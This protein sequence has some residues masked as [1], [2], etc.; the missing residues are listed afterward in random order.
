MTGERLA[1]VA[2]VWGGGLGP[3]GVMRLIERFGTAAAVLGA[4]EDELLKARAR[5]SPQ[6]AQRVA[7]LADRLDAVE[8]E[9]IRLGD[10]E[11]EVVCA[12]EPEF[13]AVLKQVP[14]PP[15]ILSIRGALPRD[16]SNTVAIVGTRTP[17]AQGG[18]LARRLAADLV[19]RGYCIVSGLA[20]GTDAAGHEGALDA[21]GQTVAVLG[22]GIRVIHPRQNEGLAERIVGHGA[23]VSELPPN[24][25]P[26]VARLMARNRL[27]A[28]LSRA[29]IVVET[30]EAGGS[31]STV[32][33]GLRQQRLVLAVEW[34]TQGES[35][36]GN[37]SLVRQGVAPLPECYD[38]EG[39]C[40]QIETFVPGV[41]S[42]AEPNH[43]LTLF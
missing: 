1:W 6:A 17:S 26:S 22:S 38:L 15:V 32:Q 31:I 27:Q 3:R 2:L 40:E 8:D 29:V 16:A 21:G 34:E 14:N 30:R 7:G 11:V 9:L 36:T 37:A 12:F 20:L 42:G 41:A 25:R 23:L 33:A 4:N 13:P 10:G 5:L 28:A 35:R 19:G 24:A 39:L 18:L 43:Q